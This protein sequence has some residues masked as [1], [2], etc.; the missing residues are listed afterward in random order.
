[1]NDAPEDI[2]ARMKRDA[3][4][5]Q[6]RRK[7]KQSNTV[8]QLPRSMTIE[9]VRALEA[10]RSPKQISQPIFTLAEARMGEIA[11]QVMTA[12]FEAKAEIYQRG[13]R[14]MRPIVEEMIDGKGRRIKSA[15][16]VE[17]DAAYL[18]HLLGTTMRWQRTTRDGI[19]STG[20]GVEIPKAILAMRGSWPFPAL[21]GLLSTPTLRADG[22]LLN[23]PGYDVQTGLL[24]M[25]P[26]PMPAVNERPTPEDASA[27]LALLKELLTEFPFVD[28]ASRA[29]ALSL[30]LSTVLRGALTHTP[31]HLFAA[32]SAG[33]GKSY[34]VDI[35]SMIA[36]GERAAVVA[37]SR[38]SDEREKRL[39]ASL[40]SGRPLIAL[41][42]LSGELESDLLC[43]ITSQSVVTFRPLGSSEEFKL[44]CRS[45][46]SA[47]GNN[48]SIADDLGRRTML[49][50]LDAKVEKPWQRKFKQNPLAE[51][52]KDRGRFVA[53]ALTIPL[54]YFAARRE[55]P[56]PAL[57]T[58]ANGFEQW[59]DFVRGPLVWLG[60]ADPAST[61]EAARSED[62]KLQA[63]LG[64]F[65]AMANF[66][67]IGQDHARTAAQIIDASGDQLTTELEPKRST[68]RTALLAIAPA[69][70]ND[71]SP[72]Q[73]GFWL[74]S[75]KQQI[76]GGMRL[77]SDLDR[78]S[79]STWW[80]ERCGP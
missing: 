45:V 77:C 73:L 47:N 39:G 78:N 72:Q 21:T 29:V 41:D 3:A 54:A 27:G 51:V 56:I 42:N 67:G 57:S 79:T 26:P 50:N 33:S 37:A 36:T 70:A 7:E 2:L 20:P 22:S 80:I 9:E 18:K 43:Q 58:V 59:N 35:A 38:N 74:R 10:L 60:E 61:F 48:I 63:K 4:L 76:V 23:Q 12:L 68:L 6:A 17:L 28:E 24:L 11:V 64:V 66:I 1:M 14:L 55:L 46:V 53:A 65:T 40:L 5:E 75:A 31:L 52:E 8:I 32:P 13:G 30:I 49:C 69:G 25:N 19:R 44:E 15:S 34:L 71:I 62:P 16:L